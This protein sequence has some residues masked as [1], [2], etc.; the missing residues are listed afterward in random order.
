MENKQ[1]V[2]KFGWNKIFGKYGIYAAFVLMCVV[3]SILNPVFL[4]GRNIF[5]VLRQTSLVG[6]IAIGVTFVILSADIDLSIGSV[7]AL[8]GVLAA[9][10]YTGIYFPPLNI[11][12]TLVIALSASL[13]IGL[14]MGVIITKGK[15]HPFVI[16]LGMLSIARGLAL[17]YAKGAPIGGL[18]DTF[19]FIGGGRIWNIPIPLII[20]IVIAVASYLVLK[21]T[22]YGMYVYAI[23]GNIEATRLSGINVDLVRIVSFGICSLLAGIAGIILAARVNSGEPVAAEGWELDAIAA[24]IIGGTSL[25]GGKG[26]IGATVVGAMFLGVLRNGLNLLQVSSFYQRVFIGALIIVAVIIDSVRKED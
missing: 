4:S 1:L 19:L 14:V 10:F 12:L 25:F 20:F 9:G 5:N 18:D 13:V 7:A 15:V 16:T 26:G 23:G 22:P 11:F 17:I 6:I 24:T 21:K 8:S 2:G 3:I